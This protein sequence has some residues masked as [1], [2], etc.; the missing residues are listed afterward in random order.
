MN[1]AESTALIADPLF[2]RVFRELDD[3]EQID[4]FFD[5][6][7]LF[8][9]L[10]EA[11][12]DKTTIRSAIHNSVQYYCPQ[13]QHAIRIVS[14][15]KD[16]KGADEY[17]NVVTGIRSSRNITI[18]HLIRISTKIGDAKEHKTSGSLL[19][20]FLDYSDAPLKMSVMEF[21]GAMFKAVGKERRP[22]C[23][24][25]TKAQLAADGPIAYR[26]GSSADQIAGDKALEDE[27]TIEDCINHPKRMYQRLHASSI[28]INAL[29]DANPRFF[30]SVVEDLV[31]SNVMPASLPIPD[32]CFHYPASVNT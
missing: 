13:W 17:K 9:R 4:D 24:R 27:S 32:L 1:D 22:R 15:I 7:L 14:W 10:I 29:K 3:T 30:N 23:R 18:S 11:K 5:V 25:R 26:S 31:K 20:A 12:I 2:K 28:V 19:G 21:D 8:V 16:E 6:G